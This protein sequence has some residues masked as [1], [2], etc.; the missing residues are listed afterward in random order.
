MHITDN[1]C[2]RDEALRAML[3]RRG[4]SKKDIS[5]NF[6]NYSGEWNITT[7]SL[8][9]MKAARTEKELLPLFEKDSV[10]C[11]KFCPTFF[12]YGLDFFA[13]DIV[14][15]DV[16]PSVLDPYIARLCKAINDIGVKTCMSCDGWHKS[17]STFS[18]MELYMTDRYSVIWFWLITEHIFGEHWNRSDPR[19]NFGINIWEPYD[20]DD[21]SMSYGVYAPRDMMICKYRINNAEQTK[22]VFARNNYYAG[23]IEKHKD[24]FLE[25]R[26]NIIEA[27]RGI[28]DIEN[29][30]FLKIRRQ[31]EDSFAADS[32]DLKNSFLCEAP[33]DIFTDQCV[34]P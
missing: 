3:I 14:P 12:G 5:E 27:L 32:K 23:F 19:K 1:K 28:S 15:F 26:K 8:E 29:A 31:L 16:A 18:Q 13:A 6:E 17:R 7:L 33:K 10:E 4:F 20:H 25:L 22:S 11:T 24:E 9:E 30:G 34:F 2:S 21:Y